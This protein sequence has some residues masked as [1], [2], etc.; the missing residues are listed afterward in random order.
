[1]LLCMLAYSTDKCTCNCRDDR[2]IEALTLN[3]H[4]DCN[5]GGSFFITPQPERPC[6]D[7]CEGTTLCLEAQVPADH[8]RVYT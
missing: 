2:I 6:A 5:N 1:M 4:R 3:Y 7:Q 8:L